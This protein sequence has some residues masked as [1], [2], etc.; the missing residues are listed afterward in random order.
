MSFCWPS[1]D[2]SPFSGSK[3]RCFDRLESRIRWG[4]KFNNTSMIFRSFFPSSFSFD[5]DIC[6]TT[7]RYD[8]ER[9]RVRLYPTC[10]M[11]NEKCANKSK[12]CFFIRINITTHRERPEYR[13]RE[14]RAHS[15]YIYIRNRNKSFTHQLTSQLCV[16]SDGSWARGWHVIDCFMDPSAAQWLPCTS[17]LA[18][19]PPPHNFISHSI[20][21]SMI[22]WFVRSVRKL[23]AMMSGSEKTVIITSTTTERI[24]ASLVVMDFD[25][26][27]QKLGNFVKWTGILG[28]FDAAAL[29]L[30]C[31]EV[32]CF[33]SILNSRKIIKI[34]RIFD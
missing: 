11:M 4:V 21:N 9:G 3:S 17:S 15:A 28:I 18:I 20:S 2:S 32:C 23:C 31:S 24:F 29:C 19:W 5:C 12:S 14:W 16:D 33:C 10:M 1:H 22:W 30:F 26:L 8:G 7:K 25:V 6:G 27:F 34:T 13:T